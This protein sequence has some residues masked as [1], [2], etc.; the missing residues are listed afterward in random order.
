MK[1]DEIVETLLKETAGQEKLA[2]TDER[3]D[4]VIVLPRNKS[5]L[6]VLASQLNLI[7]IREVILKSESVCQ[8][9]TLFSLIC[10]N[11]T[12]ASMESVQ[13]VLIKAAVE[14]DQR[15]DNNTQ[16]LCT[17]SFDASKNQISELVQTICIEM[18]DLAGNDLIVILN[19]F[20]QYFDF[21][22]KTTA[23][24]ME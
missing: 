16:I 23:G 20:M 14:V 24:R 19:I 4:E 12:S 3:E 21:E 5:Q 9:A 1:Q 7:G 18:D 8:I 17:A 13:F 15:V 22:G 10:Q 11:D 2:L 6:K